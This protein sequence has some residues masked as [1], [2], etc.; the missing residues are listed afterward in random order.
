MTNF[1]FLV[2]LQYSIIKNI[3]TWSCWDFL[4]LSSSCLPITQK[5]PVSNPGIITWSLF[6]TL[7]SVIDKL[8]CS[9]LIGH[10]KH[11]TAS[12]SFLSYLSLFLLISKKMV[13]KVLKVTVVF[14]DLNFD[15]CIQTPNFY[16]FH[17][18]TN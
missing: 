10:P 2:I 8:I 14:Q 4:L 15:C 1:H 9:K 13:A 6:S 5:V 7:S 12:N 11:R 3:F 17:H 16:P 18:R